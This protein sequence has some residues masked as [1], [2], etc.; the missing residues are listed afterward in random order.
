MLDITESMHHVDVLCSALLYV[1]VVSMLCSPDKQA[2]QDLFNVL[3]WGIQKKN[4]QEA[5]KGRI[6]RSGE[7]DG[8]N[9]A[10]PIGT[11]FVSPTG[12]TGTC[13]SSKY[14]YI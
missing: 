7:D 4:F 2:R 3:Q 14:I 12:N 9:A 8:T 10:A 13:A 1:Y 11:I 6:K 5:H